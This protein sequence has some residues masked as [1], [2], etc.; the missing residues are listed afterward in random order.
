[1]TILDRWIFTNFI[2]SFLTALL[3]FVVMLLMVEIFSDLTRYIQSEVPLP[4][5]LEIIIFYIPKAVLWSIPIAALFGMS[6]SLG[7]IHSNNELIAVFGSGVPLFRF[8][9]SC[10]IFSVLLSGFSIFFEDNFV[11]DTLKYQSDL[12]S[13]ALGVG[14]DLSDDKVTRLSADFRQVYFADYFDNDNLTLNSLLII[15]RNEDFKIV[16]SIY[17]RLARWEEDIWRLEQVS[18]YKPNE[19][20]E[21]VEVEYLRSLERELLEPS[22]FR[23]TVQNIEEMRIDEAREY[24][25]NIRQSGIIEYRNALTDY[26]TRWSYPFVSF[27]VIFISCSIGGR[28]KKNVLLLSL[29][30]SLGLAV[31]Y[32]I[33]QFV[34]TLASKNGTIPPLLGAWGAFLLFSF[35]GVWLFKKART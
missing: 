18:I 3:F 25:Q 2:R 14:L 11:I 15:E 22:A 5:I 20:E 6:F 4:V 9:L 26:Y 30:I 34:L 27:I 12:K 31:V 13:R 8:V 28:L 24:V 23:K 10:I 32:Y 17:A 21:L 16:Q 19:S 1:M 35:L 29:A 7:A 33:T